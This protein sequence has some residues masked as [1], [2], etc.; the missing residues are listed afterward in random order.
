MTQ[1]KREDCVNTARALVRLLKS[2]IRSRQIMT[3]H[4]R[5]LSLTIAHIQ[6]FE[7]AITVLMA[8]GGSTNG[9]LHLLALAQEAEVGAL[10]WYSCDERWC[11]SWMTS[12]ALPTVFR[13]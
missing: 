4:V 10:L 12:R 5:Y 9:V 8:L 1:E 2:G 11:L 7:N 6:A 13:C 3:R